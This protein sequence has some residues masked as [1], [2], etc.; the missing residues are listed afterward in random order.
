M[1][2]L[3]SQERIETPLIERDFKAGRDRMN[4]A[5]R[6]AVVAMAV[7]GMALASLAV[8]VLGLL[9]FPPSWYQQKSMDRG[10]SHSHPA[11]RK[12]NPAKRLA[13]AKDWGLLGAGSWT[14]EDAVLPCGLDN[15]AIDNA[16]AAMAGFGTVVVDWG[17]GTSAEKYAGDTA[18]KE[19]S[20]VSWLLSMHIPHS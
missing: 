7:P 5:L 14:V 9:V 4:T 11:L 15:G 19:R 16:P 13:A 10:L 12:N 8:V 1:L 6:Q 18:L 17:A 20:L 3:S 2:I